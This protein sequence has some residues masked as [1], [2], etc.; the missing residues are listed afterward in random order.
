[1]AAGGEITG[2]MEAATY[3]A[4]AVIA[5]PL[6][7]R[8]KLG[9]IVGYLA[10]GMV[11]GPHALGLI[12][13]P[14][15]IARLADFGVV[16]LLFV[17]G[18]ELRPARLWALR[19][20]IFG[21][22]LAQMLTTAVV[23]GALAAI[24]FSV[25]WRAAIIIG[26]AL[27]LSS[28]AFAVQLLRDQGE[29][30]TPKGETAFAVLLFQD[31]A[32]I[33]L[34][35]LVGVL[36]TEQQAIG[37]DWPSVG[38]SLAAVF[39]LIVVGKFGL[40]PMFRVI[41]LS[42]AREVQLAAALLVVIGSAALMA[43]LDLSMALG[44]FLAGVMLAES[45]FR[46]QLEAD[47]EPFRGLLLG[48]FF[49]AVGMGLNGRV[50]LENWWIVAL[51]VPSVMAIKALVIYGLSLMWSRAN[52]E[53]AQIAILL[54]QG[55]EFGFVLFGSA[56]SAG[57]LDAR[58]AALLAAVVT[59]SMALTAPAAQLLQRFERK[60]PEDIPENH[61][62]TKDG[63]KAIVVGYGRFGQVVGQFLMARGFP[64][65]LIDSKP[66]Q[67]RL[68]RSFGNPVYF[69][70]GRRVD[71]LRAAGAESAQLLVYALDGGLDRDTL[72]AVRGAFPHVAIFVRAYDRRHVLE[73][74]QADA[75]FI[76]RETFESAIVMARKTLESL[77]VT[78]D[79]IEAIESEFRRRD[80]E[81]LRLQAET[82]DIRSGRDMIFL[83]DRPMESPAFDIGPT[84]FET[85]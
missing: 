20:A 33:P 78:P 1:M 3:L 23:L 61:I 66:S 34:L 53:A 42:G 55:G 2:L 15:T 28:T 30:N 6:F 72:N 25:D 67:I 84:D 60:P 32:I 52:R 85:N 24:L 9:A 40:T 50:I 44:A 26:S 63:V 83:P 74:T 10:A 49:I 75:D 68:S 59:L 81:R 46:H 73:L 17:I 16:L 21:L 45:E 13:A 82:G 11:I 69:G 41:A 64:V 43:S 65:T 57:L 38:L 12:Q 8:F 70:D 79:T 27:A 37:V 77:A 62:A 7:Q 29:L 19:N 56:L 48:L 35:I 22:G 36:T 5:V 54:S 4:A 76:V 80:T 39:G 58:L 71:V 14:E 51:A 18:L 47:I 31:L